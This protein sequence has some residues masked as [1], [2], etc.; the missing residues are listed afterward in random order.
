[1]KKSI[2]IIIPIL[3]IIALLPP[4]SVYVHARNAI[5]RTNLARDIQ[6]LLSLNGIY[7]GPMDGICGELTEQAIKKYYNILTNMPNGH[8]CNNEVRDKITHDLGEI[9]TTSTARS[10][11]SQM[12]DTSN[13]KD[14]L[15]S[16]VEELE[17]KI[18][19]TN[20]TIKAL[21]DSFSAHFVTQFNNLASIGVSAFVTAISIFIAFVAL[22]GN[23]L[24]KDAVKAAHDREMEKTQTALADM[25]SIASAE[26]GA[27]FFAT[28]GGHCIDLYKD[29][30]EPAGRHQPQYKSYVSMAAS[31][32]TDGYKY[33]LE[34][35]EL[36]KKQKKVVEETKKDIEK[37]ELKERK[38]LV[39]LN[40]Y[41]FYLAQNG[42]KHAVETVLNELIKIASDKKAKG[43]PDWYSL[44]DTIAWAKLHIGRY[45]ATQTKNAVQLLIDNP[46][47]DHQWKIETKVR[48]DLHDKCKSNENEK[49]KLLLPVRPQDGG[50]ALTNTFRSGFWA[51]TGH[52][53]CFTV[54]R[55][56]KTIRLF[57]R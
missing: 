31:I 27:D 42:D 33:S 55:G 8:I 48:Y 49:V 24:I 10:H 14:T 28:L 30:P 19:N 45:T 11:V 18:N 54:M 21:G 44:E 1:M 23:L 37:R 39:C 46:D 3:L 51:R 5:Q 2:F 50:V 52:R 34:L 57:K 16:R 36:M 29:F 17:T 32:A 26:I 15:K 56:W 6:L 40:N 9:I 47:I 53:T 43:D 35:K 4:Y 38:I 22:I 13:D 41:V 12:Q 25:M 20:S 7:K